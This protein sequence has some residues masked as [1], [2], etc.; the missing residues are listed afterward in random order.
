MEM[1]KATNRRR[2][3]ANLTSSRTGKFSLAV[4][5]AAAFAAGIASSRTASAVTGSWSGLGADTNW[6]TAGN[7]DTVPGDTS[8]VGGTNTD[9]ALFSGTPTVTTVLPDVN[10]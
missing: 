2:A 3:S 10:R 7:W 9:T 8:G 4:L 6:N 5:S 1:S